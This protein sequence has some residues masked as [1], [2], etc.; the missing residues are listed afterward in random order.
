MLASRRILGRSPR[1]LRFLAALAIVALPTLGRLALPSAALLVLPREAHAT[2]RLP[3]GYAAA[4]LSDPIFTEEE[5]AKALAR[6]NNWL[7]QNA[8]KLD[9]ERRQKTREG[10]YTILASHVAHRHAKGAPLLPL[11]DDLI[12]RTIF[13]WAEPLGVYGGHHVFNRLRG[14]M[15]GEAIPEMPALI[16]LPDSFTVD[17]EGDMLA[18]RSTRGGWSARVP[19][20][21][22]PFSISEFDT[23]NGPRTQLVMLSTG[24]AR[25][26]GIPGLSQSNLR[27]FAGPGQV[28]GDFARYWRE[29]FGFGPDT[30]RLKLPID[31]LVSRKQ[32]DAEARIHSEIVS[33]AGNNGP[34]VVYYAGPPGPYEKNRAHFLDFVRSLRGELPA[35]PAPDGP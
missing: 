27:L 1:G 7:I 4:P 34:L 8:S 19:F 23:K 22:M 6:L 2:E 20:W 24:A 10:L 31:G 11:E 35:A 12:M 18:L 15:K 26:E 16:A 29:T 25:H 33:W 21:F 14:Q 17:L 9:N 13:S 5:V 32:F 28:G 3:N 30:E